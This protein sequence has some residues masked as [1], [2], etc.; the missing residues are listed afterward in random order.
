MIVYLDRNVLSHLRHRT[1]GAMD[2]DEATLRMATKHG[3]LSLSLSIVTVSE[4]LL[5]DN[6]KQ[7]LDE[8]RWIVGLTDRAHIINHV[9]PLLNDCFRA[10]ARGTGAAASPYATNLDLARLTSPTPRDYGA[11]LRTVLTYKQQRTAWTDGWTHA[12]ERWR[13]AMPRRLTFK[14]FMNAHAVEWLRIMAER[15]GVL[16]QCERRGWAGLL[17][18]KPIRLGVVVPLVLA[19]ARMFGNRELEEAHF[20]DLHHAASASPADVFVTH[21]GRLRELI[22]RAQVG[23][24]EVLTLRELIRRLQRENRLDVQSGS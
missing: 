16:V 24:M 8:I 15:A 12:M 17:A 20:G 3:H 22:R 7:A 2:Q 1:R 5:M 19:H 9:V 4:V 6:K 23:D 13:A 18:L 11:L 14:Q 21:D 10:Y